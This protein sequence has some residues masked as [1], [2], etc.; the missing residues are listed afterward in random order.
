MILLRLYRTFLYLCPSHA[1]WGH[2]G[3]KSLHRRSLHRTSSRLSFTFDAK[4]PAASW[5]AAGGL[6]FDAGMLLIARDLGL[7]DGF[8]IDAVLLGRELGAVGTMEDLGVPIAHVLH[9]LDGRHAAGFVRR[10]GQRL[11]V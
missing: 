4:P 3:P 1:K 8:K 5:E 11:A 6:L 10:D 9:L 2:I 7:F